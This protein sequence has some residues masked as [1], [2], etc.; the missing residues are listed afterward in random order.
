MSSTGKSTSSRKAYGSKFV[1]VYC[2]RTKEE[3]VPILIKNK[4]QRYNHK[5]ICDC[6]TKTKTYEEERNQIMYQLQKVREE[7][8]LSKALSSLLL[9]M[10]NFD[11]RSVRAM[12]ENKDNY[13]DNI[14]ESDCEVV[15]AFK[16]LWPFKC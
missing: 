4:R 9:E 5:K 1:P 7:E 13:F 10:Q 2:Q 12:E 14:Y 15:E 16:K 11:R 3:G 8:E 6:L